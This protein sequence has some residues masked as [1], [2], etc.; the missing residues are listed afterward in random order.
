[1]PRGKE[2]RFRR[3]CSVAWM[4]KCI[5]LL[6]GRLHTQYHRVKCISSLRSEELQDI[7]GVELRD[8][9]LTQEGST[10]E[11]AVEIV[12]GVVPELNTLRTHCEI[13]SFGNHPS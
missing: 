2:E 7:R 10:I 11:T 13:I 4:P 6:S 9:L 1:M 8:A 5:Q 3:A 12:R